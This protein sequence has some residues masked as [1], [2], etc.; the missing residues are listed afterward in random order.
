MSGFLGRAAELEALEQWWRDGGSSI[1][2]IWGRR[3]AGKTT[4]AGQFGQ[5]KQTLFHTGARRGDTGELSILADRAAAALGEGAGRDASFPSWETA[6]HQ[7][8]AASGDD[9]TLLVLDDVLDLTSQGGGL[10]P[11]LAAFGHQT[12]DRRRLRILLVDRHIRDVEALQRQG[13]PLHGLA[14]PT[15]YLDRFAPTDVGQVLAHLSPQERARVYG[16]V[17]G[18]PMYL[19]WWDQ[20]RNL[21]ENLTD[22]VCRPGAP[23]LTEGDLLVGADLDDSG[24]NDRVL[25]ALAQ[26]HTSYNEVRRWSGTEPARPLERLIEQRLIN[27]VQP[28]GENRQARR[29]RYRITDPFVRFHLGVVSRHRADIDRGEV[30]GLPE[31]MARAAGSLMPAVWA[32]ACELHLRR[33]NES[34]QLPLGGRTG[35]VGPWWDNT[36]RAEID[37]LVVDEDTNTPLLAASFDWDMTIS[38]KDAVA[39]LR[40]KVER[41]LGAYPQ[42]L[43]YAVC[44][45][46]NAAELP[47][48]ALGYTA[49][50]VFGAG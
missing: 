46:V 38:A 35:V 18:T 11:A 24:F 47:Y 40:T 45:R 25:H 50:D 36:G 26:G 48:D 41:R 14:D 4:L 39:A 31:R 44:T 20:G 34:G 49:D 5:G 10:L 1:A 30:D 8:A 17:G 29:R 43:R 28:V 23:L 21:V 7:L 19:R 33:L 37:G 32:Q 6:L 12:G 2:A 27:R 22:L 42:A 13:G 16:I 9:Q 3:R 15:I